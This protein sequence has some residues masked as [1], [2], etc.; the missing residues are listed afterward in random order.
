MPASAQTLA[1]TTRG[2]ACGHRD[3]LA[4][5]MTDPSGLRVDW[6]ANVL[7]P[8]ML[9]T[10][11]ALGFFDLCQLVACELVGVIASILRLMPRSAAPSSVEPRCST[12]LYA[13]GWYSVVS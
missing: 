8:Y 11:I 12:T 10:R 2:R 5:V 7:I 9:R 3:L 1:A 6:S 13:G 4:S